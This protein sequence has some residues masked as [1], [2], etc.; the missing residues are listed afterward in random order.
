MTRFI[1][2]L[3][4]LGEIDQKSRTVAMHWL[5]KIISYLWVSLFALWLV[6]TWFQ[7]AHKLLY[8]SLHFLRYTLLWLAFE[9]YRGRTI[10]DFILYVSLIFEKKAGSKLVNTVMTLPLVTAHLDVLWIQTRLSQEICFLSLCQCKSHCVNN[11]YP[12]HLHWCNPQP[13]QLLLTLFHFG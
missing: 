5:R 4:N 1:T 9:R 7:L 8:L 10:L 6:A 12:R 11:R 3:L 2:L 13:L